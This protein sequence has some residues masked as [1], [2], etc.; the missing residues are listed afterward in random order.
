M[1]SGHLE[2]AFDP[3]LFIIPPCAWIRSGLAWRLF[4][5][6]TPS[7]IDPDTARVEHVT[8]GEDVVI[9]FEQ[10]QM[11]WFCASLVLVIL[12]C[13]S[14]VNADESNHKVQYSTALVL[15]LLHLHLFSFTDQFHERTRHTPAVL[16]A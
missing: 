15:L 13:V 6:Q 1:V 7:F 12:F 10:L 16:L 5:L 2:T 4:C 8:L 14:C 11:R 3:F 9:F